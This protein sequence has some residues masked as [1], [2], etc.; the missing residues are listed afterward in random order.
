MKVRFYFDK[1]NL[2]RTGIALILT[3][4]LMMVVGFP[5]WVLP[6]F[7]ILYFG[8]KSLSI[9]LNEKWNGIF[10]ALMLDRKSVV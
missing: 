8:I 10:L 4:V 2:G 7:G 6:C 3:V 9:Q 5:I 1:G